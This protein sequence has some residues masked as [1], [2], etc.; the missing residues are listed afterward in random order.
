MNWPRPDEDHEVNQKRIFRGYANKAP[1][2]HPGRRNR[3]IGMRAPMAVQPE[4]EQVCEYC[5]GQ[6]SA[7]RRSAIKMLVY[8]RTSE[9]LALF[10][11]LRYQCS[12]CAGRMDLS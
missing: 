7:F 3:A 11:A 12:G 8:D 10:A 5:L 4:P 6:A 9:S 1:S 2:G